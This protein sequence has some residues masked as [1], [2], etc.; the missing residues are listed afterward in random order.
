[1]FTKGKPFRF[2]GTYHSKFRSLIEK[3]TGRPLG[4]C[5]DIADQVKTDCGIRKTFKFEGILFHKTNGHLFSPDWEEEQDAIVSAGWNLPTAW[6]LAFSFHKDVF[7]SEDGRA[8]VIALGSRVIANG[9][10]ARVCLLNCPTK[11]TR[12]CPVVYNG[13]HQRVYSLMG[14]QQLN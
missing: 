14:F 5:D 9:W 12:L 13:V 4:V 8:A 3:K 1:M 6:H 10:D 7:P 2:E 11:G